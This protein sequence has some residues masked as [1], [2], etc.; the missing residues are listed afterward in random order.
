M[1]ELIQ[2]TIGVCDYQYRPFPSPIFFELEKEIDNLL[3]NKCLACTW[4]AL[5]NAEFIK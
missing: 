2:S 4:R 1:Y 5:N 3:A